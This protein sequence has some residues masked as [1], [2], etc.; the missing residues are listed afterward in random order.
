MTSL[1]AV[2]GATLE[3]A[4]APALPSPAVSASPSAP[5]TAASP[6]A[7]TT[8]RPRDSGFAPALAI[9]HLRHTK[10]TTSSRSTAAR[11]GSI[12]GEEH[13]PREV[14]EM[15]GYRGESPLRAA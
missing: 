14:I 10:A 1:P 8:A 13:T 15:V 9:R 2:T 7:P 4:P 5:T 3:A 12:F 6:S 11:R